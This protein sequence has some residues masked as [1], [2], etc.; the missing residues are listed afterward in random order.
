MKVAICGP[1]PGPIIFIAPAGAGAGEK[2]QSPAAA[3]V[4]P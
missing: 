1:R 2:L 3:T 4:V